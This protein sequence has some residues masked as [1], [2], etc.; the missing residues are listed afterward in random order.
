MEDTSALLTTVG[1]CVIGSTVALLIWGRLHP[2]VPL[3][4]TPAVGALLAGFSTAEIGEFFSSGLSQVIEV[5]IMLIFAIV[6]FGIIIDSGLF[7]PLIRGL[8][9]ATR[10][11]VVLV[12]IGTSLMAIIA[13]VDGA[14][15]STF[16]LVIPALLPLYKALNMSRYLLLLLVVMSASVFNMIPWGGPLGRAASVVDEDVIELYQPL[17]AVQ[18]IS[19]LLIV[20]F[21]AYLGTREKRRIAAAVSAGDLPAQEGVSV[22]RIADDF[23]AEREKEAQQ[24]G[25][26]V[27]RNRTVLIMNAV[28]LL[29]VVTVMMT[30]L[31]PP[32]LAFILGVA[33]ALPLNVRTAQGQME[34]VRAHAPAALMTTS[35]L[36]AA[37]IFLGVL[38]ESGMLASI[39]T[40]AL[41]VVPEAVGP[42]LH[43][44]V[45]FFG[46][47]LDLLT[48]TDAY[49]FSLLP[50]VDATA[51]Q[52]GVDT[53]STLYAM[54]IGNVTGTFMSPF[55]AGTWLAV[56]LVGGQIGKHIRY[57]FLP[58]WFMSILLILVAIA[59]GVIGL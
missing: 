32:A 35:I 39:A 52:F 25:G 44:V 3:A 42:Q 50:L 6:F 34:R 7:N 26:D 17:L 5:A 20:L 47:P 48:S 40:S 27:R 41:L 49:Y 13:H 21:A 22:R 46:V 18:A 55:S 4:L 12:A 33:A 54:L 9:L 15:A 10:G 37:S 24:L 59:L 38:N 43:L 31:V 1:L 51:G 14:G 11:K 8:I 28:L 23:S 58:L 19:V 57:S 53:T 45:G 36:F 30:G 29:T 2:I 56:G 16:L